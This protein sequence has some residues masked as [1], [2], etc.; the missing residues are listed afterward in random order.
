MSN[1]GFVWHE[2]YM[3][4]DTGSASG[5]YRVRGDLQPGLHVENAETK[6]KLKNL[7]DAYGVTPQLKPLQPAEATDEDLPISAPVSKGDF[8]IKQTTVNQISFKCEELSQLRQVYEAVTTDEDVQKVHVS[9][10]L[11]KHCV[12]EIQSVFRR[13][14]M[15]VSLHSAPWASH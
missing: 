6:R 10:V 1:T 15:A 3:W 9:D 14:P 5:T 4:H 11:V 7:L 2:R 13:W 12:E 8:K